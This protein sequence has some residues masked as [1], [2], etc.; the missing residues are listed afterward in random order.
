M[1]TTSRESIAH[2]P[3]QSS[4][5]ASVGY[6]PRARTLEVRFRNGTVYQY[7]EVPNAIFALFLE[8]SSKGTFFNEAVRSRFG[9][10]RV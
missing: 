9:H 4:S 10:A 5:V 7:F 1:T 8:A 6:L 3:V 2:V